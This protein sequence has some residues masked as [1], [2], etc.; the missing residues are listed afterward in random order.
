MTDTMG[1]SDFKI[2]TAGAEPI[3]DNA[4]KSIILT[5]EQLFSTLYSII[6]LQH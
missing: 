5:K 1:N 2:L 6:I 3:G 4:Q